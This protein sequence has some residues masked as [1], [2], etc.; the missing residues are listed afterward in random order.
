MIL[1]PHFDSFMG[2]DGGFLFLLVL[3]QGHLLTELRIDI[4]T[5]GAFKCFRMEDFA[6]N[7]F[8]HKSFFDDSGLDF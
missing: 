2:S 4:L 8:S 7:R 5:V 3:L 6:T 1:G